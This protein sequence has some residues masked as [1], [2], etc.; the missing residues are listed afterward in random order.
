VTEIHRQARRS[1]VAAAA[2][3]MAAPLA[4]LVPHDTGEWL[5]L[6]LFLVGGLL[7]AISGATQLLAVTW[8]SSPAPSRR[9]ASVQRSV[10]TAGAIAVAFGRELDNHTL[11]AAGGAAVTTA[12][13]LLGANLVRIRQTAVTDRFLPAIDGY[14]LAVTSGILGSLLAVALVTDR[15]GTR[16]G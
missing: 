3:T 14:L 5:P 15:A 7:N 6:H 9:A 10:L 4:V 1:L 11:A 2:F 12:L 8:S 13:A 16:W